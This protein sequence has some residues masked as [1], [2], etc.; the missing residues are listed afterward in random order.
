MCK[1]I[2]QCKYASLI[3][4]DSLCAI[5]TNSWQ[6]FQFNACEVASKHFNKSLETLQKLEEF[7]VKYLIC[8]NL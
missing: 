6:C 7:L 3:K 1:N 2:E 4:V 5:M 8:K